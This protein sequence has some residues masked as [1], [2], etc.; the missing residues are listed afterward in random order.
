MPILLLKTI[1]LVS[2]LDTVTYISILKKRIEDWHDNDFSIVL[3]MDEDLTRAA[4]ALGNA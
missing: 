1:D 3:K 2:Y 4:L